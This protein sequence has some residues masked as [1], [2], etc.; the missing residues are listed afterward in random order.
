MRVGGI[1]LRRYLS[2]EPP[3]PRFVPPL[4]ALASLTERPLRLLGRVP[5]PAHSE[6]RLGEGQR[7]NRFEPVSVASLQGFLQQGDRLGRP[8]RQGVGFAQVSRN[9]VE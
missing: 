1:P 2:E 4:T 7:G 5:Y 9:H 3:E 8:A 6:V